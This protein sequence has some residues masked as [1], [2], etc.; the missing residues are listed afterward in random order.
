M[1]QLLHK[2]PDPELHAVTQLPSPA[3][4]Q[5]SQRLCRH[6]GL[7]LPDLCVPLHQRVGQLGIWGP[8]CRDYWGSGGHRG[9][10]EREG[11]YDCLNDCLASYL[12]RVRSLEA[13]NQRLEIKIWEHL[14]EKGPR[15]ETGGIISRSSRT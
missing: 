15:S 14:K 13:D 8:G 4:W 3:D 1:Y 12:V 9:H 7:G 10:P 11:E 6:Q 5:L 2:L